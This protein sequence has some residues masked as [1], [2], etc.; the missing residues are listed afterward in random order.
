MKH[1]LKIFQAKGRPSDNPLI[2]HISSKEEP[3]PLVEY[4]PEKAQILMDVF[5]RDHSL[6]FSLNQIVYHIL[7]RQACYCCHKTTA[8]KNM[9]IN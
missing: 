6:L 4:I 7:L 9:G 2:V 8:N 5:C 3:P 1:P